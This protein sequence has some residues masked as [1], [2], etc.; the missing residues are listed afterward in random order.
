MNINEKLQH[1]Y[2]TIIS[3]TEKEAAEALEQ[4]KKQ[5]SQSLEEHKKIKIQE[6]ETAVKTEAEQARREINRALSSEHLSLKRSWTTEQNILKEAL[7][8]QVKQKLEDFMCSPAYEDYLCKR[9]LEAKEFAGQEEIFIYLSST[10]ASRQEVIAS[11]TE[12]PILVSDK[13]FLGGIQAAI[14]SK[15]IL[16]NHSFLDNLSALQEDFSFE[17]GQRNA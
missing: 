3:D 11:R 5:L 1:F 14:P 16:I 10:D 6:A 15:N 7:F 13:A 8:A 4:H 9:V 2:D 12:T 17:G